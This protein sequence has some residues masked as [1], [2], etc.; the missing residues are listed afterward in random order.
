MP[1]RPVTCEAC[2]HPRP[3]G[4]YLLRCAHCARQ[5]GECCGSD[6]DGCCIDCAVSGDAWR[7][8][9]TSPSDGRQVLV[10]SEHRMAVASWHPMPGTWCDQD[11]RFITFHPIGWMPR[12]DLPKAGG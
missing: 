12:P 11:G 3:P 5:Y 4:E 9:A 6:D 1:T 8:M 7:S 2:G 10:A